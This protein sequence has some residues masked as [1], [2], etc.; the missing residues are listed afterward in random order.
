M[1]TPALPHKDLDKYKSW[2]HV[3]CDGLPQASLNFLHVEFHIITV[4]V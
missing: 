4:A 1:L 3:Q 2:H